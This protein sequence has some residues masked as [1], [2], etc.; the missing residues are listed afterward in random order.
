MVKKKRKY[1]KSGKYSKVGLQTVEVEEV[2]NHVINPLDEGSTPSPPTKHVS[3]AV[4]SKR[5]IAM[6]RPDGTI[7]YKATPLRFKK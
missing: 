7:I 1:N 4:Q 5:E 6:I 2:N 3:D